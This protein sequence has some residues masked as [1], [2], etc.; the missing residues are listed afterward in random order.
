MRDRYKGDPIA[1]KWC[2]RTYPIGIKIVTLCCLWYLSQWIIL[3][4][5][6]SITPLGNTKKCRII[7]VSS[8]R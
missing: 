2:Q 8:S 1:I 4:S 3:F 7:E 5:L 6:F